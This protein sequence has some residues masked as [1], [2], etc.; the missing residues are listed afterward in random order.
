MIKNLI[1]ILASGAVLTFGSMR[2]NAQEIRSVETSLSFDVNAMESR[3]VVTVEGKS[4]DK[5]DY[6]G[7][8]VFKNGE[9]VDFEAQKVSGKFSV[10]WFIP[11]L[12][13]E[14][15]NYTTALWDKKVPSS[16]HPFGY[17]MQGEFARKSGKIPR[18]SPKF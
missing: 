10:K 3:I 17:T 6:M 2:T 8:S 12:N 13:Y 14:E 1:T 7:F 4:K 16:K 15:E 18:Y 5:E 9:W 11:T